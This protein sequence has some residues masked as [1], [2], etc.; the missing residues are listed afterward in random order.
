MKIANVHNVPQP[1]VT[2][3]SKE[4]YSKGKSDYSVTEL[5]SPPRVRRLRAQNDNVMVQDVSE[6]LWSLLGSALHVVMERGETEGWT[7]EERLFTEVDGVT[8]SGAIDLQ[9]N[10]IGRAHV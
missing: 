4:Y 6:M 5:M 7:P 8:I 10:K 3:A 1:L 9:E 2:L